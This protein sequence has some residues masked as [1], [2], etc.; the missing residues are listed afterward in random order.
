MIVVELENRLLSPLRRG[1]GVQSQVD[2]AAAQGN[3]ADEK[4]TH[5]GACWAGNAMMP[6]GCAEAPC[7]DALCGPQ[8]D[9]QL[10][11]R[12]ERCHK[13]S[14]LMV[15]VAVAFLKTHQI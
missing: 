10:A 13:V 8:E 4:S 1:A 3:L 15:C 9:L 14:S 5:T 6:C 11:Q 12:L 7:Y 2:L